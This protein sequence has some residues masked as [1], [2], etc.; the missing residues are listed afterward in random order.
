MSNKSFRLAD[1][2][3]AGKPDRS[4]FAAWSRRWRNRQMRV[5]DYLGSCRPLNLIVAA[6]AMI[7]IVAIAAHRIAGR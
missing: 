1:R 4:P 3:G 7:E 2:S 6:C 5:V